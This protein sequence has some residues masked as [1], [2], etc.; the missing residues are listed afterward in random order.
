MSTTTL[1][2][3]NIHYWWEKHRDTKPALCELRTSLTMAESEESK[4]RYFQL[5]DQS[6][7]NFDG[8]SSTHTSSNVP[9]VYIEAFLN[10]SNFLPISNFSSLIKGASY[11]A[12]DCHKRDSANANRDSVVYQIRQ[13]GLR[14]DG[15]PQ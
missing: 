5:F 12:S 2:L 1:S 15:F 6:F 8:Y 4:V 14:V 13:E 3:Y 10:K 11:I 7:R 9:R